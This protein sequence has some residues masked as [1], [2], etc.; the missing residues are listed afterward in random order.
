MIQNH[1][2][3]ISFIH[4]IALYHS[5]SHTNMLFSGMFQ[6]LGRS[7]S[8]GSESMSPTPEV[9]GKSNLPT[10]LQIVSTCHDMH[11]HYSAVATYGIFFIYTRAARKLL[12]IRVLRGR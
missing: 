9:A 10:A 7:M 8:T 11:R 5:V 6:A 1:S 12:T 4:N 2:D 3:Y